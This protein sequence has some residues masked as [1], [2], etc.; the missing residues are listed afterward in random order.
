MD[1]RT[2]RER[3]KELVHQM[4]QL[5]CRGN[6]GTKGAL[7]PACADLTAY[8]AARSDHC[9][10][11]ETKTFCSNCTVHC[12]KSDMRERIQAV[13]RYAGPRMI[14]RRPIVALRHLVETKKEKRRL[15][16]TH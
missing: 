4:I 16:V 10:F 6:H 2:K 9:P 12:Y 14:F 13:M 15:E 5:Y 7:C 8:A 1:V 11:I 3:E